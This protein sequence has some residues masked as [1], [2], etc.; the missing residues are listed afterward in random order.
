MVLPHARRRAT[1]LGSI[2][3]AEPAVALAIRLSGAV[4]FPKQTQCNARTA[5]TRI[6]AQS[7]AVQAPA[8]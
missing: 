1:P 2:K 7:R 6:A 8:R 4:F 5:Q 3:V